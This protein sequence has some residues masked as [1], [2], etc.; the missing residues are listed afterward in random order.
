M[1]IYQLLGT[2]EAGL[3]R[4]LKYLRFSVQTQHICRKQSNVLSQ[5][6]NNK[7]KKITHT[8]L[9]FYFRILYTNGSIISVHHYIMEFQTE[10][11]RLLKKLVTKPYL[12]KYEVL[13]VE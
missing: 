13:D 1:Y 9:Q 6:S 7:M 5:F 10:Q 3:I 2:H 8:Y 12:I 11:L 4:S